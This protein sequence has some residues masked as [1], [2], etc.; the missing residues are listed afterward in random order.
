MKVMLG[1]FQYSFTGG[2]MTEQLFGVSE[3]KNKLKDYHD[4]NP[5]IMHVC[6]VAGAGTC[7]KYTSLKRDHFHIKKVKYL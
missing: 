4:R 2:H 5:K 7:I 1:L 6:L 3:D